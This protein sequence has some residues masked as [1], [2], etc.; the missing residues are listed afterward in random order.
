MLG[1]WDF[2]NGNPAIE[3]NLRRVRAVTPANPRPRENTIKITGPRMWGL[4]FQR[5]PLIRNLSRPMDSQNMQHIKHFELRNLNIKKF[6]PMPPN[7]ATFQIENTGDLAE[8]LPNLPDSVDYIYGNRTR[9]RTI[10]DLPASLN[11]LTFKKGRLQSLPAL[12]EGTRIVNVEQNEIEQLQGQLPTTLMRF[13]MK[14]NRLVLFPATA[15]CPAL[16]SLGVSD[17]SLVGIGAFS[18]ALTKIGLKGNHL[19]RLPDLPP[20]LE[21]LNVHNNRLT[22]LPALP[23]TLEILVA[24]HNQLRRIPDLPPGLRVLDLSDNPLDEPWAAILRDVQGMGPVNINNNNLPNPP[25]DV[26]NAAPVGARFPAPLGT[27]TR[28]QIDAARPRIA[29]LNA[30][31]PLARDLG[32]LRLAVGHQTGA[33]AGPVGDVIGIPDA[34]GGPLSVI[35]SFLS[36]QPGSLAQ[37]AATL[38]RTRRGGGRR[39]AERQ[40]RRRAH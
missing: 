39:K 40:S 26:F 34:A 24:H 4:D 37:Q 25:G 32:A 10:P 15:Q 38:P 7:L 20:N 9:V 22:S 16:E 30:R 36:G 5:P 33:P 31:M 3:I 2:Q 35:G 14:R 23:P 17:N 18:P 28:E 12:P 8:Q 27:L 11:I 29:E 13:H 6:P 21:V 1:Q 19:Q